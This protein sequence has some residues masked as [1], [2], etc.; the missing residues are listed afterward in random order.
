MRKKKAVIVSVL[1]LLV[2][3]GL[4]FQD[5]LIRAYVSLCSG[6]LE[7][8]AEQMLE[9]SEKTSGR[10]G[11]WKATSYPAE[12]MVEF[13]TGGFGLAPSSTYKGFYYAADNVH[14]PFSAAYSDALSMVID[15]DHAV[16]TDGTDN[17]GTSVRIA[18]NWFWFRAS[19]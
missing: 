9:N 2:V 4:I 6:S 16:W 10:Y 17:N 8:Y 15:G 7:A 1:L 14:K 19:F 13:R 5:S 3:L 11:L 18:E 12:S